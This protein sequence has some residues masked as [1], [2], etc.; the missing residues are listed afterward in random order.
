MHETKSWRHSDL[1]VH[2]H[3]LR[4][5]QHQKH[6]DQLATKFHNLHSSLSEVIKKLM[7]NTNSKDRVLHWMR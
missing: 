6:M 2:F 4:P 3:K 7:K 5:E 1:N